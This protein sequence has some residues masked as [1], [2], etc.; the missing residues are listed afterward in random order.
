MNKTFFVTGIA[1]AAMA[2]QAV[3]QTV[4]APAPTPPT[5]GPISR[6]QA[7]ERADY[8][9]Q[10]LD[11]NNDGALTMFEAIRAGG[12][13]R[14]QRAATGVDVAPGIGG[15]TARYMEH[16]LAGARSVSRQQF[17]G[18]MIA[19]FEEMDRNRDGILTA[20]ERLEGRGDK[21][22]SQ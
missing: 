10:A 19:H 21:Q 2:S 12:R 7:I 5:Q 4:A 3:A 6:Q 9:F 20:E 11:L 13:L 15:H 1:A 8:L 16:K 14:A 18:A 17:E 22:R